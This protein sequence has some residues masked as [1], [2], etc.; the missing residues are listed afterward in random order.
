MRL[1]NIA[2]FGREPS[3]CYTGPKKVEHVECTIFRIFKSTTTI[4][5]VED[6][7]QVS[8]GGRKI[9]VIEVITVPF[10]YPKNLGLSVPTAIKTV[11]S[12]ICFGGCSLVQSP[13][14]KL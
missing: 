3:L 7:G 11:C 8:R 12:L 4:H 13:N 14:T 2:V 5:I 1:G 9:L 6:P 10:C